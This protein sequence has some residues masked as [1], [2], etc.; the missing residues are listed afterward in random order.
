MG[1]DS[2]P[3]KLDL[4]SIPNFRQTSTWL[5]QLTQ[6]ASETPF[7][8]KHAEERAGAQ[9]IADSSSPSAHEGV[10]A[11]SLFSFA[12]VAL[13]SGG[14]FKLPPLTIEEPVQRNAPSSP[15]PESENHGQAEAGAGADAGADA[16]EGAHADAWMELDSPAH[17]VVGC[18]T[19]DAF[20]RGLASTHQPPMLI[21][22]AGPAAYDALLT[23]NTDPLDLENLDVAIVDTQAYF[24]SLLALA[25][26]RDSL[27]FRKDHKLGVFKPAMPAMRIS[28]YSRQIL[29]GLENQAHWCGSTLLQLRAFVRSAYTAFS[30]RCGVA[31]ASSIGQIIQAVEEHVATDRRSAGPSSL[32]RLRSTIQEVSA[33]LKHFGRLVKRLRPESCDEDVLSLVFNAAS[34]ADDGEAY[35]R[36]IFRELLRRVSVPW[37][38]MVEEW[39]GTRR[40]T[41]IPLTKSNLGQAR[42]FIKVKTDVYVDDFGREIRH[43]D[44]Q[45]AH[46]KVPS[47]MPVDIVESIFE[48]GRNLRFIRSFHPDNSLARQAVIESCRPPKVEWLYDWHAILDLET[49]V[50]RYHDNLRRAMQGC[51][52]DPPEPTPS[53]D[54]SPTEPGSTPML[55]IFT[56][57]QSAMEERMQASIDRLDQPVV[58]L[59]ADDSLARIVQ[60]RLAAGHGYRSLPARSDPMPH[61]SLL[62]VLSFGSVVSSQARIVGKESVRLLFAAH[63]LRRHL[64]LLR[65]FNLLGSGLFCSRLSHALFD[66]DLESAE[67]QPGVARQ[68]G[69]MGLRLGGRDTWPPASSELRLALMGVLAESFG[70]QNG[71]EPDKVSLSGQ[72]CRLPGDLSFAVRDLSPEE[73]DRCKDPR[74]LAALDFLRL[75]YSTPSELLDM[76]SPAHLAHYD[77]IFKLLLRLLRMLYLVNQLHRDAGTRAGASTSPSSASCR[78]AREAHHFV[79]SVASYFW[80]TGIAVPWR[81]FE[82][83]L[84]VLQ[85]GLD[86]PDDGET[87]TALPSPSQLRELHG[88]V[89]DRIMY[90]LF[91]TTRQEPVLRLLE[92]LLDTILDYANLSRT[93]VSGRAAAD[94]EVEQEAARLY[95]NFNTKMGGF[96]TVCRGLSE[97][98]RTR[99]TAALGG[100]GIGEDSLVAQLLLKLDMG[101]YYNVNR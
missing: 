79:S 41:G 98:G 50:S 6:D 25:L 59:N 51:P 32:L 49:R 58:D 26:G 88:Q 82:R 29:Q 45:L 61:W 37:I 91:L 74:S 76:I 89:L 78:F 67:R 92:G 3:P 36:H 56:L 70:A 40:E 35:I 53:V 19:W 69:V 90:A 55:D 54:G 1:G 62:P 93:P 4:F 80:D 33:V 15:V 22:E 34:S 12:P 97:K 23:W 96:I 75:S 68:G 24:S 101:D 2:Y 77:V 48:T 44:F 83:R 27:L 73:M 38:E 86:S 18:R 16:D 46:D 5:Q 31:L 71:R 13:E 11:P 57:D 14:F 52:R 42:G 94:G 60:G 8:T 63:D 39:I 28:G 17:P 21:S 85:A 20:N 30:S 100:L 9:E 84:D 95:A 43:V 10:L 81:A 7:F 66:P 47:F 87:A 65:D 64:K 72:S 99:G